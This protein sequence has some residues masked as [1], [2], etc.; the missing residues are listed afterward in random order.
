MR[1]QF[2]G[3]VVDDLGG[4]EH[5]ELLQ[6]RY[7]LAR[8]G[9]AGDQAS[10]DVDQRTDVAGLDLVGQHGTRPFVD[11]R[12]RLRT[13]ARAWTERPLDW[14]HRKKLTESL[15]LISESGMKPRPADSVHRAG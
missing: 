4:R 10:S 14:R 15:E 5:F 9:E 2:G 1:G 8:L 3:L 13:A 12:L 7:Q 11:E 6:G